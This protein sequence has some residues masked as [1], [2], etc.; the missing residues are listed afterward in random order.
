VSDAVPATARRP[1]IDTATREAIS[2][3]AAQAVAGERG[4]AMTWLRENAGI[5]GL[6]LGGLIS[7]GGFA[8]AEHQRIGEALEGLARVERN[9]RL[10]LGDPTD[11][12]RPGL[13]AELRD[14]QRRAAAVE[15]ASGSDRAAVEEL[16]RDVV[17][18]LDGLAAQQTEVLVRLAR[19]EGTGRTARGPPAGDDR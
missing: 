1:A 18:R 11:P 3:E 8:L 16:R 2:R 9:E 6:L 4:R 19:I 15:T 7:M 17:R 5:L 10:L 14:L 13:V 12:G